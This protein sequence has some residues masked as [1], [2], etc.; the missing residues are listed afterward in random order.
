MTLQFPSA[1]PR[2][3]V[4]TQGG[5]S[6]E[7]QLAAYKARRSELNSQ[8]MSLTIRR[9]L[10]TQQ[11]RNASGTDARDLNAQ[12]AIVSQRNNQVLKAMGDI[13]D[14][15]N[16]LL[17]NAPV[18]ATTPAAPTQG[19]AVTIVPPLPPINNAPPQPDRLLIMSGLGA[20]VLIVAILR[21]AR[22]P[23]AALSSPDVG[24]LEK[25]QQS[26]DAI[27]IEVE[28][29][30]ESH[31]YLS[32]VLGDGKALGAGAAQ[33]LGAAKREDVPAARRSQ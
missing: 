22:R 24:R 26:V 3:K 10:L 29:L 13:D 9:D 15:V 20:V 32:K 8:L 16:K 28:R 1:A 4:T 21:F 17:I 31:R 27:A 12:L 30:G 25:L 6:F 2:A 23:V 33:E 7:S 18:V 14:A 5:P 19:T 11:L